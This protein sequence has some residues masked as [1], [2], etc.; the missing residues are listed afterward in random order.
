MSKTTRQDLKT[1]NEKVR[2]LYPETSDFSAWELETI[3]HMASNCAR[4]SSDPEFS[5]LRALASKAINRQY[6]L[7]PQYNHGINL[8]T[9]EL[10]NEQ[11]IIRRNSK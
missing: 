5:W 4:N 8:T 6:S 11:C 1:I 3:F 7:Y 9:E 10:H 2:G